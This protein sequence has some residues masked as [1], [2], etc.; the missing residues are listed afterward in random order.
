MSP[1]SIQIQP[2]TSRRQLRAFIKFPWR[3]YEKDP[4]WVPPL[5][6]QQKTT[7]DPRKNPFYDHSQV[8]LFLAVRNGQIAGRI[9]AVVNDNHNEFHQ[10]KAGF[11]GFFECLAFLVL[12]SGFPLLLSFL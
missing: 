4:L 12:E 6:S 2:V 8:Q 9:A 3:V 1:H 5:I 7:F 10:E 11:F